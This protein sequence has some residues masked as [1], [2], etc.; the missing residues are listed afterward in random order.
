M[1]R[2]LFAQCIHTCM[3]FYAEEMV[4]NSK[5]LKLTNKF[6]RMIEDHMQFHRNYV[7]RLDLMVVNRMKL[8]ERRKI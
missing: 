6:V 1:I 4:K 8:E 2:C 7:Q 5:N 3:Y